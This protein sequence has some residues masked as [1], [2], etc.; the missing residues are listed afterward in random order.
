LWTFA[1]GSDG[2]M[3]AQPALANAGAQQPQPGASAGAGAAVPL[4]AP[5]ALPLAAP[6]TGMAAAAA[7]AS[8]PS[9]S[10]APA[11]APPDP[12]QHCRMDLGADARD[13][14]LRSEAVR[15]DAGAGR[16]D[17]L[18]PD[19]VRAWMDEHDWLQMHN[20]W[21]D[22]RKWDS[23]CRQSNVPE[24]GGTCAFA[25]QQRGK[26]LH[27]AALQQCSP[28]DGYAFL[29]M[30]RHM[31]ETLEQVFPAHADLFAG[32]THV[33]RTT[34]DPENPMP[35]KMLVWSQDNQR[36]LDRLESI[37]QHLE[38]FPTEDDLARY[39]QCS[40]L[41]TP[42]N[43]QAPTTD[44]SSGIHR[45][46]HGQWSITGSPASLAV[47][48]ID[49]GNYVFWK[50]HGFLDDCGSATASPRASRPATPRISASCSRN[51]KRCTSC[52]SIT[53]A[54]AAPPSRA[55]PRRNRPSPSA[56]SSRSEC[57]RSSTSIAVLA[58]ARARSTPTP[59]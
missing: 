56:A 11:P 28:G 39:M 47:Q 44:S 40:F 55:R 49:L 8:A 34:D 15:F 33:P 20:D 18:L 16:V 3:P 38:E 2:V 9:P 32:F 5:A 30:H 42:D 50:L 25:Q 19:A 24:D 48:S 22:V 29:M 45:G 31:I 46:L 53:P 58:T 23:Q 4:G 13:A 51:A 7:G 21:H 27:K 14:S 17:L 12:L 36:A 57:G 54:R 1:C 59:T 37:E 35:W 26:G 10:P 43:P 6:V 41:W 52:P